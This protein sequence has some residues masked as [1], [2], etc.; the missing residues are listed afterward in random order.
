MVFISRED[1]GC[2]AIAGVAGSTDSLTSSAEDAAPSVHDTFTRHAGVTLTP[3]ITVSR[4]PAST[5]RW[6]NPYKYNAVDC[7]TAIDDD[8]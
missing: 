4:S 6:Q 8:F 5:A 2:T 1:A 3:T 7:P